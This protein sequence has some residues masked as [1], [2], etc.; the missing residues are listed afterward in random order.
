MR[1]EKAACLRELQKHFRELRQRW[2]GHGL[3]YWLTEDL[4]NAHLVSIITYQ[5]FAPLFQQ[6]LTECDGDPEL[7]FKRAKS[8]P[9]LN[10]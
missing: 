6:L 5:K 8:L 1:R 9:R 3:Q 7:F 2:G 10:P 4:N